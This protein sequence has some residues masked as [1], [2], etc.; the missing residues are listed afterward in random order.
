MV[1]VQIASE[2]QE[3]SA[4]YH[5]SP[6]VGVTAPPPGYTVAEVPPYFDGQM[7]ADPYYPEY[8]HPPRD[9]AY[10][11]ETGVAHENFSSGYGS[12]AYVNDENATYSI[13]TD[14][15]VEKWRGNIEAPLDNS[16]NEMDRN[17]HSLEERLSSNYV[18]SQKSGSHARRQPFVSSARPAPRHVTSIHEPPIV[19]TERR[20]MA[21]H[22]VRLIN[23]EARDKKN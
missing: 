13:P 18:E 14:V 21:Q 20:V 7:Y 3:L 6:F 1:F 10:F 9:D 8:T 2:M 23:R 5:Q 16:R 12:D 22:P 15:L 4:Q 19:Q 11:G 17:S